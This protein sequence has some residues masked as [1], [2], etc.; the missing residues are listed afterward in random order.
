MAASIINNTRTLIAVVLAAAA[1]LGVYFFT[2][3]HE[4][5]A[6]AAALLVFAVTHFMIPRMQEDQEVFVASGVTRADLLSAQQQG[7]QQID[8][9]EK[10]LASIPDVDPA[11]GV[12]R[13]IEAVFQDIYANLD[14]DP[15]DIPHARAFLD[16]HSGD[17]ISLIE[18]Y[19]GLV[20]NRLPDDDKIKQV[21][22]ARARFASIEKAFRS[23][24]NAMLANDISALEQAGRNLETSLRLE[25]G[26]ENITSRRSA[27]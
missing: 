20:A 22:A 24:Y 8:R 11:Q 2:Q 18:G 21:Q 7:K 19:A 12:L 4:L 5:I 9:L 3:L 10:A 16:F 26:L 27:Q 25:H 14:K 17:A 23:Q 15:G 13:D 6:L 1:G